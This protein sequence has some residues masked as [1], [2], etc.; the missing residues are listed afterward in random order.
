MY[1]TNQMYGMNQYSGV[2]YNGYQQPISG[3]GYNN[4]QQPIQNK[5][6]GLQ[7]KIIDDL[8]VVKATDILLDGSINYFPLADGSAIATKQLQPNGTSKIIIYRPVEEPKKEPAKEV[9]Y[10][11]ENDFVNNISNIKEKI[12]EIENKINTLLYKK[13]EYKK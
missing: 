10:I 7:G 1:N 13:K 6:L 11:T 3:V 2:G 5:P 12:N 4:F 9:K 8:E